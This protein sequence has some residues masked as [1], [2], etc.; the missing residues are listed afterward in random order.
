MLAGGVLYWLLPL[1]R[2]RARTRQV[3]FEPP[4]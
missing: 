1:R 3:R 2:K 4:R